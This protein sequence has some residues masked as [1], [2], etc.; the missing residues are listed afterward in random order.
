VGP[1][2]VS[3]GENDK[4]GEKQMKVQMVLSHDN[5]NTECRDI[6]LNVEVIGQ[7]VYLKLSDED[8]EYAVDAED[9]MNSI[10]LLLKTA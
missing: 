8:R 7:A 9:L 1:L 10:A 4:E 2:L 3:A 6:T 5:S